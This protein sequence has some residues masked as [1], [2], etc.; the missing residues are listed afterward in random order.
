MSNTKTMKRLALALLAT[1]LF[2]APG[3]KKAEPP[4]P[5]GTVP[6]Y[7]VIVD[8]P[9]LEQEFQAA[10]PELQKVV[11]TVK[12]DCRLWKLAEAGV[13]LEKLGNEPSLTE[14]QKKTVSEVSEQVVRALAKQTALR[15]HQQ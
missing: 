2:A 4:P 7:G 1:G 13:V 9:K 11:Q 15:G 3:C 14:S 5:P 10:S 8:I 12:V 6:R